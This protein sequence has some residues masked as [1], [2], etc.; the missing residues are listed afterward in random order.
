MATSCSSD[1]SLDEEEITP[2]SVVPRK[3]TVYQ[4]SEKLS[5][6]VAKEENISLRTTVSENAD[7]KTLS[8]DWASGDILKFYNISNHEYLV[9]LGIGGN[10][11]QHD[12]LT[13]ADENGDGKQEFTGTVTCANGHKIS[14]FY[15]HANRTS[16]TE[17]AGEASWKFTLDV[18]EQDGTLDGI[19]KNFDFAFGSA[20]VT[21]GSNSTATATVGMKNLAAIC[22]FKFS[23]DGADLTNIKQVII[24]GVKKSEVIDLH[25][26]SDNITD[27]D[28]ASIVVSPPSDQTYFEDASGNP[29]NYVYVSLLPGTI[30]PTISVKVYDEATS[31]DKFYEYSFASE[32]NIVASKY[33]RAP[34]S[35]AS[36]G[37]GQLM[38]TEFYKGD[39]NETANTDG[40]DYTSNL[41]LIPERHNVIE[42]YNCG[43]ADISSTELAKYSLQVYKSDGT[44]TNA[45][46]LSGQ[47]TN[48]NPTIT[49]SVAIGNNDVATSTSGTGSICPGLICYR[50]DW[51]SLNDGSDYPI[52]ST[53]YA[54]SIRSACVGDYL[55]RD[56]NGEDLANIIENAQAGDYVVLLYNGDNS[57]EDSVVDKVLVPSVGCS[58]LRKN[59]DVV[60]APNPTWTESEWVIGRDVSNDHTGGDDTYHTLG[61][62]PTSVRMH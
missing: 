30:K 51:G 62:R 26:E 36:A 20:T 61:Q 44:T 23:K 47:S 45:Y 48:T 41:D 12:T 34:M 1:D 14:L 38:I 60:N 59:V 31:T 6:K 16:V 49:Y 52:G 42:L 11:A 29:V 55:C 54:S 17:V 35:N 58:T 4:E 3:L 39:P 15:P 25:I 18:S 9:S 53:I 13:A 5:T 2:E 27:G 19:A 32:A 46:S 33:Y 57:G 22:K 37:K 10:V 7:G 56:T 21:A 24:K 43:S 8:S 50:K 40:E 28:N